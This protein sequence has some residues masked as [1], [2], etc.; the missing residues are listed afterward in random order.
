MSSCGGCNCGS[1]CGCGSG[2][3]C[4]KKII[5]ESFLDA[6]RE[7]AVDG[8][9]CACGSNCHSSADTCKCGANCTCNPCRC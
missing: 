2:C 7:V 4:E 8:R 6:P 9:A 3:K 1:S 5:D